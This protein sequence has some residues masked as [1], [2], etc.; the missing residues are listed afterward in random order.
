MSDPVKVKW[1]WNIPII[2]ILGT[3][4]FLGIRSVVTDDNRYGWG[5][6]SKQIV[7]KIDYYWVYD[8]G[9]S[10]KYYP[11]KELRGT[12]TGKLKSFGNTRYSTGAVK[13]WVGNYLRYL[14]ENK[15]GEDIKSVRA[16]ILYTVNKSRKIKPASN[17]PKLSLEYPAAGSVSD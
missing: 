3:L 1:W 13:S 8:D 15:P 11:G 10:E 5:T 4:V 9:R 14:Y 12:A 7:Y 17:S 6:F 16:H 2:L